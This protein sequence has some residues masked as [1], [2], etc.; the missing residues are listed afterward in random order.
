[1]R[2]VPGD[3]RGDNKGED[4][5]GQEVAD[6]ERGN[7]GHAGAEHFPDADLFFRWPAVNR[8]SP[9]R[10]MQEMAMLTAVATFISV[11]VFCSL[12]YI[13]AMDSSRKLYLKDRS[14]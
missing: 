14:G 6:Q 13:A 7:A 4:N 12:L 5:E 8:E 10:P 3:G 11:A 2:D 1:M 9:K